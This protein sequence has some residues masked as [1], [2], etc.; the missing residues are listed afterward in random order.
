MTSLTIKT[1]LYFLL[2][3]LSA[4]LIAIGQLG[5]HGMSETNAGLATVYADRVVPLKQLKVIADAYAV[6][7]VDTAHKLR[8]EQMSWAEAREHLA[9]AE[10]TIE[11]NWKSYLATKLVDEEL[12][13]SREAEVHMKTASVAVRD[14]KAICNAEDEAR[15]V[16][17]ATGELY[18][19]IDPVSAV[20]AKLVDLQLVV[21]KQEFE[22]ASDRYASTRSGAIGLILVGIALALALG[23]FTIRNISTPVATMLSSLRDMARGEGDLTRRAPIISKDEIGQMG[24]SFN[25]FIGKLEDI[26]LDIRHGAGN[27]ATASSQVSASSQSLSQGTSEISATVSQTTSRLSRLSELVAENAETTR[28][29]EEMATKGAA[30]AEESGK[31]VNETVGAMAAIVSKISIIEDIAYKTHLLSMNAAI[32]AA[33]AGEHGRGFAVLSTE[34]RR[35]A[36]TSRKAAEEVS[37]LA[38]SS[39]NVAERSGKLIRELVPSIRRT[40]HLVQKVASASQEQARGI[41]EINGAFRQVEQVTQGHSAASEELSSTAEEMAAQAEMMSDLVGSFRVSDRSAADGRL[42]PPAPASPA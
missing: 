40:A 20:F 29:M 13:L 5:L 37:H 1:R 10:R 11:S 21:A 38:S 14:L 26:I 36:D 35:L 23:L 32:E 2:A 6:H 33:L 27:L 39:L 34:V 42:R 41:G 31:A 3:F 19:S 8:N 15:L 25:T 12:A 17:F 18:P 16:A 28:E 4:L 22:K 24:Q 9:L 7:V 30:D